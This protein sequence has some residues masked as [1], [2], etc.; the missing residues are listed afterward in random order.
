MHNISRIYVESKT[1]MLK[2]DK[3][4]FPQ[5]CIDAPTLWEAQKWLLK[6]HHLYIEINWFLIN[7]HNEWYTTIINI[8][9]RERI[10]CNGE[11]YSPEEALSVGIIE[12]IKLLE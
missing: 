5:Y 4:C 11:Y 6:E 1:L 12:C 7:N 10:N 8:S 3:K 9:K 2:S